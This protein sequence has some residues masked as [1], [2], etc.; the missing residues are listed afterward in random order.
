[1]LFRSETVG[2]RCKVDAEGYAGTVNQGDMLCVSYLT[3]GA[4]SIGKLV[5][6]DETSE[7]G[8]VEVVGRAEE[9]GTD[10]IVF[11][12]IDPYVTTL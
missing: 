2:A 5:S 3:T 1:M 11:K 7:T 4:N 10:Y 6:V 12:T 8:N 9:V